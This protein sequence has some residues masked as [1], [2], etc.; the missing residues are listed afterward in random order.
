MRS[1]TYHGSARLGR[2]SV[3]SGGM[4]KKKKSKG[5]RALDVL[6]IVFGVYLAFCFVSARNYLRPGRVVPTLPLDLRQVEIPREGHKPDPAW[7]TP[8]LA[9]G[10][11]SDVVYVFAHGYGGTRDHYRH[12]MPRL[13]EKGFDSV[14]PAMPGQDAS[15]EPE[16]GFG[17]KEAEQMV[18]AANW[19][20]SKNPKAKIVYAG[21]SMGGAAAWMASE[22]DPKAA[23]VI[24]EGAYAHFDEAM[25]QYFEIKARGSSVYLRPIIWM[26][27]AMSGLNPADVVPERSAEKWKGKPGLVIHCGDDKL[28]VKSH[29]DRLA[30]AAG[31]PL[32]VIPNAPHAG[33]YDT[34]PH[35]YIDTLVQFAKKL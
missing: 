34:D 12:L 25:Y 15:P 14:A 30:A 28:M 21:V 32:L 9:S 29:A 3:V 7:A 20:R 13:A 26:A 22:K 8:N 18:A 35:L 23:G 11:G 19:V 17:Y 33:G 6:L 16:V 24:S 10:G 27:S 4:A 5:R 1:V 31:C 2:R